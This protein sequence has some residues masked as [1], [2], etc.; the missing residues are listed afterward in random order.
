[1]GS[2]IQI[3][4]IIQNTR[5][6]RIA[7]LDFRQNNMRYGS[8]KELVGSGFLNDDLEDG[9]N[10]GYVFE[11]INEEDRYQLTVFMDNTDSQS[12]KEDQER[13]S[14]YLDETGIIRAS[15]DP[16]VLAN[17]NSMPISPK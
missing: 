3:E 9:K 13:L 15:F 1:M 7:Q 8:L 11:L 5:E 17:P 12:I 4:E 2:R 10:A 14:L 6:I 16:K